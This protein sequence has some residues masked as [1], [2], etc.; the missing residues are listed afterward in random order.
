MWDKNGQLSSVAQWRLPEGAK[1]L[2]LDHSPWGRGSE[3]RVSAGDTG[4]WLEGQAASHCCLQHQASE[5]AASGPSG[6]PESLLNAG[7]SSPRVHFEAGNGTIVGTHFLPAVAFTL[8]M[9]LMGGGIRRPV[10][11]NRR[12]GA[13]DMRLTSAE[14]TW[15]LC[16]CF[17]PQRG[18]P[19]GTQRPAPTRGRCAVITSLGYWMLGLGPVLRAGSFILKTFL[20]GRWDSYSAFELARGC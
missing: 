5:G 10:L 4:W 8:C 18:A 20:P 19:C 17:I 13:Q 16:R 15:S 6:L 3:S 2:L 11:R 12:K 1:R 9:S 7:P 14:P